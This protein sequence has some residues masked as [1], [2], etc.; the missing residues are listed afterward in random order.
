[1]PKV[2]A[3]GGREGWSARLSRL[4]GELE[5]SQR[6]DVILLDSRAGIDEVASSCVTDL[7]AGLV[8]LFAID[9]E[10]TWTGYRI[11]FEHWQQYDVAPVIRERLKVVGAMLPDDERRTEYFDGLRE[12][13]HELFLE[14]LYDEIPA[15]EIGEDCWTFDVDDITGQ[16]YPLPIGWNRGFFALQSLHERMG[17]LDQRQV[18]HVFAEL[19]QYISAFVQQKTRTDA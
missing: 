10:Q 12:R 6:P 13:S 11:L 19:I 17:S 14:A 1:M 15:G 7:G 8:L 3:D 18:D 9:G 5:Q 2:H 16:H 4:I